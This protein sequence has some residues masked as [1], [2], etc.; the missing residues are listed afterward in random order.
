MSKSVKKTKKNKKSLHKKQAIKYVLIATVMI[1]FFLIIGGYRIIGRIYSGIKVS[2]VH[3][4]QFGSLAEPLN[5]LGYSKISRPK[6]KCVYTQVYGYEGNQL[7]CSTNENQFKEIGTDKNEQAKFTEAA[8][9]LDE[10]LQT[11]GWKTESNSAKNF[12]EWVQAVAGG[13]DYKTDINATKTIN[14]TTCM[15]IMTVAYSNPKPPAINT[16][17]NC[18]TPIYKQSAAGVVLPQ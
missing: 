18:T 10:K 6:S 17:L 2:Y 16:N 11:N 8:A 4:S 13:T 5:Q 9:Q 1:G 7:M 14:G 12:K 3:G 15:L